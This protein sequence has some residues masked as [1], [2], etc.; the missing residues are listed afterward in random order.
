MGRVRSREKKKEVQLDLNSICLVLKDQKGA[1]I[2]VFSFLKSS[3]NV[4]LLCLQFTSD[5]LRT[6]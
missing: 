2:C 6:F 4:G 1:I 5:F 3:F